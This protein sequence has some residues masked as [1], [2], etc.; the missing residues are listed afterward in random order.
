MPSLSL[1]NLGT[2]AAGLGTLSPGAPAG[3]AVGDLL[4][5]ATATRDNGQTLTTPT[6]WTVWVGG[7]NVTWNYIFAR[8]ADGTAADTPTIAYTTGPRAWAQISAWTGNI[9][10]DLASAVVA[11][12]DRY[13]PG[14]Q[15]DVDYNALTVS[16]DNCLKIAFTTKNKTTLSDGMTFN[17]FPGMTQLSQSI[18]NGTDISVYWGYHQDTTAASIG[19]G[20]QTLNG[21]TETLQFT[22]ILIAIRTAVTG[23]GTTTQG[24][25]TVAASAPFS[26]T[27]T[28][29]TS[30]GRQTV[31][32]YALGG[33]PGFSN[34]V[35]SGLP[36][37]VGE[38]S[39]LAGA[40]PPVVNGDIMEWETPSHPDGYVVDISSTGVPTIF[41]NGDDA[42]QYFRFN[43]WDTSLGV[44][45]GQIT[46]YVNNRAPL[47]LDTQPL[48]IYRPRG[49]DIVPVDLMDYIVDPEG[50]NLIFTTPDSLPS[51]LLQVDDGNGNVGNLITG[52]PNVAGSYAVHFTATDPAGA[53][54]AFPLTTIEIGNQAA[55][56]V[57]QTITIFKV[58]AA[59][60]GPTGPPGTGSDSI[61]VQLSR[62]NFSILAYAEGTPIDPTFAGAEGVLTVYKGQ[63]DDT[64]N[65]SLSA[66]GI[67]CTGTINTAINTPV[68]GK[69]KGYYHV[70]AMPRDKNNAT[71]RM[72]VND[73]PVQQSVDFQVSKAL[74]GYEI[75]GALPTSNLFDGR[76]V[77]LTTDGKLYRYHTGVGWTAAVAATDLTGQL[78]DAQIQAIAAAKLTGQIVSTQITDGAISTPK[79]AAG[80]VTSATIAAGTI[81]A[82]D[83]A[84]G[85]ITATELAAGS[86]IA[87]KLAAN[88]VTANAIAAGSIVAAK[89]AATNVVTATA[90]I[91]DLIV[92]TIKIT[93]DAVS[94]GAQIYT[95]GVGGGALID[96]DGLSSPIATPT[97]FDLAG[98]TISYTSSG[99]RL[100]INA[101]VACPPGPSGAANDYI[102]F[103]I[104][105]DTVAVGNIT[106]FTCSLPGA[107]SGI[108]GYWAG[109]FY[110]TPPAGTH[111]Y[112][113]QYTCHSTHVIPT[114]V[115]VNDRG[116][117]ILESKR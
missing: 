113:M 114:K 49:A 12:T 32:G 75:V 92:N 8:I 88:A 106:F 105:R 50:Q 72:T 13:L 46:V 94:D 76:M 35:V 70:T 43:V 51:A 110:D 95:N 15:P 36:W 73:G 69:A 66:V 31:Q 37:A 25:E 6:G 40:S 60:V 56:T 1:R 107:W 79:L 90:Q 33:T 42:G 19:A 67:D 3:K 99:G 96:V 23:T 47:M 87:N 77:Y 82:A 53:A 86:V 54:T 61:T 63:V 84:A 81:V 58:K 59:A 11:E 18:V 24:R 93:G 104:L 4:I 55:A 41:S 38:A 7:T 16:V 85:S 109:F 2:A 103:R 5:L 98:T 64:A 68:A 44:Y 97:Y 45:Y 26:N 34:R 27:G 30:Q 83:I 116:I 89:L 28:G 9:H 14:A 111:I 21:Y 22:S 62:D 74:T 115:L 78:T 101:F 65:A 80:S 52:T 17:A 108:L 71:L 91:G 100:M 10:L 57:D 29:T 20:S 102:N 112:K 39:L 48:T 117:Q